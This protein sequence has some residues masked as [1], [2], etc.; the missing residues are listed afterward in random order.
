MGALL[1]ILGEDEVSGLEACCRTND[2]SVLP[3][4]GHVEG[5]LALPLDLEKDGVHLVDVDHLL[6]DLGK[7]MGVVFMLGVEE[8]AFQVDEAVGGDAGVLSRRNEIR[9]VG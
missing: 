1:A 4:R 3:E 7:I 5:D 9:G 6:Q 8:V 2:A